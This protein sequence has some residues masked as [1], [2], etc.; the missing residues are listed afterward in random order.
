MNITATIYNSGLQNNITVQTD[1][2]QKTIAIPAK[3]LGNGSSVN[4]GELL[5]LALAT[6]TCND[7]YREASKRN[8]ELDSVF[9]TVTGKFGQ[10]GEPASHISYTVVVHSPHNK[11]EIDAL[12]S[13]V[14][15]IAEIHNTVRK[16]LPVTLSNS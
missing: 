8:I 15:N 4:G 12:I 7:L 5:F 16:G 14:D 2:K 9:V 10:E 1:G 13:Y 6:C 11:E 3:A